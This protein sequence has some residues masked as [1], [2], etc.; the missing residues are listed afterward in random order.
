M[1][2]K[3]YTERQGELVLQLLHG[4]T[5]ADI[6]NPATYEVLLA[7][8]RNERLAIRELALWRLS[9]LDPEGAARVRYNP[10]DSA[11]A[12]ER[13]YL[14]WKQRIPDGKLPPGRN[15]S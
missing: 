8:L 3:S 9:G 6:A 15:R 5:D 14:L 1:D 7:C 2:R 11:E 13:A 12:R 4:F 10:A